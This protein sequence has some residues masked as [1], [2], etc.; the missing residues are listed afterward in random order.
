MKGIYKGT[1][2]SRKMQISCLKLTL[3]QHRQGSLPLRDSADDMA[4]RVT[5]QPTYS[6]VS[7]FESAY[8]P[9]AAQEPLL[10]PPIAG[11]VERQDSANYQPRPPALTERQDSAQ[12]LQVCFVQNYLSYCYALVME[13]FG[14]PLNCPLL[15]LYPHQDFRKLSSCC[16]PQRDNS[17]L[18]RLTLSVHTHEETQ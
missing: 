4:G 14:V 17:S 10:V 1:V 11:L 8:D 15:A 12:N 13:E 16:T 9:D 6:S 2:F 5:G 3:L 7:E 18:K